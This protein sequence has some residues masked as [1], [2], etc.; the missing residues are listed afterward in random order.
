MIQHRR[1]F[2][3]I[4]LLL[5]PRRYLGG[6][7]S[8]GEPICCSSHNCIEAKTMATHPYILAFIALVG[9]ACS[10]HSLSLGSRYT[11]RSGRRRPTDTRIQYRSGA[12]SASPSS[13]SWETY[14]DEY[15]ASVIEETLSSRSKRGDDFRPFHYEHPRSEHDPLR[16]K[17]VQFRTRSRER[18]AQNQERPKTI[19]SESRITTRNDIFRKMTVFIPS[20][21]IFIRPFLSLKIMEGFGFPP[22]SCLAVSFLIASFGCFGGRR[23]MG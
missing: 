17:G 22:A 15:R 13:V 23:A 2:P 20:L 10:V 16:I 5:S 19:A 8:R 11:R 14:L 21:R 12:D 3:V 9:W 18:E 4:A 7:A 1:K 6:C